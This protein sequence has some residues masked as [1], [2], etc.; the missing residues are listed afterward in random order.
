MSAG[1]LIALMAMQQHQRMMQEQER[2]RRQE[3]ERQRRIREE[4]ERRKQEEYR[5]MVE[6]RKYAPVVCNDEEWQID[7]CIKA[8]SAQ[9]CVR[10]LFKLIEKTR[11]E[12]IKIEEEKI[13]EKISKKGYQ[14]ELIRKE[15]DNDIKKL[16]ELG[17]TID[18]E[19]YELSRLAPTN[20][21]IANI[22]EAREYFG[23]I[24]SIMDSQPIEINPN[25]MSSNDYYKKRYQEMNPDDLEQEYIETDSKMKRYHK[26]G[27]YLKFLLKTKKYIE[28]EEK[29]E[30]LTEKYKEC[31]LRRKEMNSFES[32]SVE[33]LSL[34]KSYFIHLKQLDKF[35]KAIKKLF[36]EKVYLFDE[37]NSMIYDLTIK[38]II[39]NDEYSELLSEIYDYINKIYSNDEETMKQ[40]YAF[41]KGK[42]PINISRRFIYNLIISNMKQYS[43]EDKKE[44]KITKK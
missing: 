17:I 21:N 6:H 44:L 22:E 29:S 36:K 2:R 9:P 27:K 33:Q 5:K 39:A 35:S 10:S 32:L 23:N 24:F 14:Y 26:Y 3:N 31:E 37:N 7:R 12:I 20:T 43:K 41:V 15:L 1:A 28:L 13:D 8:I 4:N 42:Y 38:D 30:M 19:Q 11:P 40:V 34:I 25:I 18:G 16:K